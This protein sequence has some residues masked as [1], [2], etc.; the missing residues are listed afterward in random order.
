MIVLTG[1]PVAYIVGHVELKAVRLT[2]PENGNIIVGQE[3]LIK[4][5]EDFTRRW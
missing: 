1:T 3:P 2:I 4:T 5:V